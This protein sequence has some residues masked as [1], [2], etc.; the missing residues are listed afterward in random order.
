MELYT[1]AAHYL[2]AFQADM[3]R[4]FH[5]VCNAEYGARRFPLFASYFC[6]DT[7]TLIFKNGKSVCSY[8]FCY[9]DVCEQLDEA[10]VRDYCAVL[11][12]MAAR[13]VPWSEP[14]HGF[15]MLSMVVLTAGAPDRAAQKA[16]KKYKNEQKRKRPEDGYGW[17]S[18]RLCVV[19]LSDGACWSNAHG[20]A[21]ANRVRQTVGK[22][23][24]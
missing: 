22:V 19:N 15:S 4:D 21:L 24:G 10:A 5:L 12:D 13:Y 16:I 8:E 20:R 3:K 7:S 17:C 1:R 14:S 23:Q 2:D 9:F 18:G 11:D 6:E